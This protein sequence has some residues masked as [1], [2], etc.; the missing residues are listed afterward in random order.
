MNLNYLYKM[1]C[2]APT[3]EIKY[4]YM[5]DSTIVLSFTRDYA[6]IFFRWISN[7]EIFVLGANLIWC[8]LLQMITVDQIMFSSNL[9]PIF[10]YLNMIIPQLRGRVIPYIPDFHYRHTAGV[11][12]QQRMLTPP[13][14][15]ILLS[16][17][18]G[19]VLPYTRLYIFCFGL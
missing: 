14:H 18:S 17:L 4:R 6:Y 9:L 11:T 7:F 5:S 10:F 19:S 2:T 12:G 3:P 16:L 8:L 13:W 15:L 1:Q